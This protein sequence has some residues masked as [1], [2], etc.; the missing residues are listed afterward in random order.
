MLIFYNGN[1]LKSG[2]Y[3]IRNRHSG[4]SYIG[5]AKEFK[6]RWNRGYKLFLQKNKCHNL[7]LQNDYN[8]SKKELDHDDFLEFHIIE[9]IEDSTSEYRS[10][11]EEYWIKQAIAEYGRNRVYN[12]KETS[13]AFTHEMR[14]RQSLLRKNKTYKEIYGLRAEEIA[15]KISKS[16]MGK[17]VSE[18]H[19]KKLR[20]NAK[21]NPNYGGKNKP[22]SEERRRKISEAHK[23]NKINGFKRKKNRPTT[24]I[25]KKYKT[26][27]IS[28]TGE[29]VLEIH[30]IAQFCKV[31]ELSVAGIKFLINGERKSHKGWKLN[32]VEEPIV[33]NPVCK[34]CT[35]CNIEKSLSL[36]NVK[37]GTKDGKRAYCKECQKKYRENS[38]TH[39]PK[40]QLS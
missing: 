22:V 27:L 16:N 21:T 11:R 29:I 5:Q 9:I 34:F 28:P 3:E 39:L 6:N 24:R 26:N 2:I 33:L 17:I 10:E 8:K 12:V 40:I 19:R 25:L 20:D 18:E 4:R 37:T 31:N 36:F 1:S 13:M 15:K 35:Q 30:D 14:Q 38:K 7:F 23:L 32:I